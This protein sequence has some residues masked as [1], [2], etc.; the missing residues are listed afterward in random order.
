MSKQGV[1]YCGRVRKGSTLWVS[2]RVGK[3]CLNHSRA[4]LITLDECVRGL[5]GTEA[6]SQGCL[7]NSEGN[8][9]VKVYSQ[10]IQSGVV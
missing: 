3:G 8:L 7:G 6:H 10:G 1:S 9:N 4:V 2:V 5:K